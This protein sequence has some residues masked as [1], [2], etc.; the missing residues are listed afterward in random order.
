MKPKPRYDRL[1]KL[2][3]LMDNYKKELPV[4]NHGI[5]VFD[6]GTWLSAEEDDY[7]GKECT[8]VDGVRQWT[9]GTSACALGSAM[10]HPWF[11][12]RG[13]VPNRDG[14]LPAIKRRSHKGFAAGAFFFGI[15]SDDSEYL[16][17][18]DSYRWDDN[19]I[20]VGTSN[21]VPADVAEH[22]RILVARLKKAARSEASIK[23]A[24]TRKKAK[25]GS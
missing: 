15:S 10:Y 12:K 5:T 2:E 3:W 13:L 4:I 7:T 25:R 6:I 17:G 8:F 23:A 14:D 19:D 11:Q 16:F 24:Q 20:F 9:C 21:I 18:P 1:K 22:V